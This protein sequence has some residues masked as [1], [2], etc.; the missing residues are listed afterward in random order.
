MNK[1]CSMHGWAV[2][3]QKLVAAEQGIDKKLRS[4]QG[5]CLNKENF[6]NACFTGWKSYRVHACM[7]KTDLTLVIH[8]KNEAINVLASCIQS[9]KTSIQLMKTCL[10]FLYSDASKPLK[11]LYNWSTDTYWLNTEMKMKHQASIQSMQTQYIFQ[12]SSVTRQASLATNLYKH[13]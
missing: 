2:R 10:K 12:Y 3:K 5:R 13:T 11:Q 7:K 9:I 8:M 4:K 6:P 1:T